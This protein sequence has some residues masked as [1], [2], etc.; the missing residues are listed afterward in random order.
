MKLCS[1]DTVVTGY[2]LDIQVQFPTGSGPVCHRGHVIPA[3]L[4]S[5]ACLRH[6]AG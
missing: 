6:L 3:L 4:L 1:L 5:I 2:E